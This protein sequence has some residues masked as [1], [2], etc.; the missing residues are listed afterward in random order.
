MTPL[1]AGSRFDG[2]KRVPL[3]REVNHS[4]AVLDGER[5]RV[6]AAAGRVDAHRGPSKE[7]LHA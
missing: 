7:S 2:G 4:A 3:D 1:A 6:S 5:R